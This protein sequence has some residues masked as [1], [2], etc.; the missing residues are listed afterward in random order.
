MYMWRHF[1]APV[2]DAPCCLANHALPS[3]PVLE[4]IAAKS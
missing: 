1:F 3:E 4:V 2:G